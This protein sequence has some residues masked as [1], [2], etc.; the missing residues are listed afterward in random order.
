[1]NTLRLGVVPTWHELANCD[2]L[3][4]AMYPEKG[5]PDQAAHAKRICAHCD[6]RTQCLEDAIDRGD[7]WGVAGGMTGPE[8]R[9]LANERATDARQGVA[10]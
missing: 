6:V 8:L 1:M 2:G 4:D 3:G 9:R 10:A 7:Y 5:H